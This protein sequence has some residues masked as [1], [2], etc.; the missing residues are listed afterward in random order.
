MDSKVKGYE[1]RTRAVTM[2]SKVTVTGGQK[3]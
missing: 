2:D 3:Q 1:R